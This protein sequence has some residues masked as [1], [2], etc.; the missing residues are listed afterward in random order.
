MPAK[1]NPLKLNKLQLRT[2][3]LAQVLAADEDSAHKDEASGDVTLTRLPHPHGN[4]V[5]VGPYVVSSKEASGFANP[6]VWVALTR[7]GLARN[8]NPAMPVLTAEGVAYDTG[9]G[10]LLAQSDH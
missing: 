10:H 6:A 2:L 7:K 3:V 9:L 1:K 8:D 5:H 4:H